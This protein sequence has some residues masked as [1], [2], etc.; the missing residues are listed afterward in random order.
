[1]PGRPRRCAAPARCAPNALNTRSNTTNGSESGAGCPNGNGVGS[2]GAA[3]APHD[4]RPIPGPM[5]LVQAAA[6]AVIV[7][8]GL[9]LTSAPD[10]ATGQRWT[11]SMPAAGLEISSARPGDQ[12]STGSAAADASQDPTVTPQSMP[13]DPF[14][15]VRVPVIASMRRLQ[16]LAVN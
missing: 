1:P 2:S 15:E 7:A 9:G 4:L 8:A 12:A 3:D 14:E 6:T 16:A 11:G 13:A 5:S 10:Q